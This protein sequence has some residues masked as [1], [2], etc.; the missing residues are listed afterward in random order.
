MKT[1]KNCNNL[2]DNVTIFRRLTQRI[3]IINKSLIT[4]FF[5]KNNE[6]KQVLNSSLI[7]NVCYFKVQTKY[8][9]NIILFFN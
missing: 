8:F 2:F 9:F 6:V 1:K 4:F 3:K 5:T 7:L